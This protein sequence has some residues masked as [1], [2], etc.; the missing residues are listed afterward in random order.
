MVSHN[1]FAKVFGKPATIS[2]TCCHGA[3]HAAFSVKHL[4]GAPGST[5][6]FICY[7]VQ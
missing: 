5:H 1:D 6:F 7:F 4:E 2:N 3:S